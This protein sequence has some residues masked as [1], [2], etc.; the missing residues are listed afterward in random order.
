[1]RDLNHIPTLKGRIAEI[2][3]AIAKALEGATPA[4]KAT[5]ESAIEVLA[6]PEL[7]KLNRRLAEAI[8]KKRLEKFLNR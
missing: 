2:E 7:D 3:N 1:M 4:T 8:G 5:V 6:K